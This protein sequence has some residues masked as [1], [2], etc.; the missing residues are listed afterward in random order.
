MMPTPSSSP[1]L[2]ELL[3]STLRRLEESQ[4]VDPNDPTMIEIKNSILRSITE[5]EVRRQ[6]AA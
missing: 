1:M 3:R 5:L 2:I 4:G 6:D